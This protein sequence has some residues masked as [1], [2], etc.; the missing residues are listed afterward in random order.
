M[1]DVQVADNIFVAVASL[2]QRPTVLRGESPANY[3]GM[4]RAGFGN[5]FNVTT[6]SGLPFADAV[7]QSI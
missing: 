3:V 5:T 2:D 7:N 1:A 6:N 4:Q